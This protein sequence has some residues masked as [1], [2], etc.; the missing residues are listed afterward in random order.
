MVLAYATD[1][2]TGQSRDFALRS[3]VLAMRFAEVVGLDD[4]QRRNVDHQALLRY[5]GCNADTHRLASA[6]GDEIAL[7]QDLSR[8]DMG[9]HSA[10]GEVFLRAFSRVFAGK[11]QCELSD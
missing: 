9:D 6:F 11:E 3:C 1:L 4:R 7:R 2:A 8:I 10:I 5:I